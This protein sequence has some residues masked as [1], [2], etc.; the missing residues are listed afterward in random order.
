MYTQSHTIPIYIN[1]SKY[2]L[3]KL[4]L[5]DKTMKPLKKVKAMEV[6]YTSNLVQE[7]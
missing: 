1:E 6:L 2:L 4:N 3:T 5:I 7:V